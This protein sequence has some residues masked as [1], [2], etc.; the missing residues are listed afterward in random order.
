MPV[1]IVENLLWLYT[2]EEDTVFDPFAG[3][4]TTIDVATKMKRQSWASD[5]TPI[6]DDIHRHN[7]T[8]GWPE[9]APKQVKLVLLDPPYWRQAKGRYSDSP[10]DLANQTLEQFN[11]SWAAVVAACAPHTD[12]LAFIISATQKSWRVTD[13]AHDFYNECQ[14]QGLTLHRR[15][16]VPYQTQQTSGFHVNLARSRRQLLTKYRDLIVMETP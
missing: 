11:A 4:G 9:E 6:R 12:H 2:N 7:I 5:L 16:I 14:R 15:I 1:Q 10:D 3:G 8:T 13:H